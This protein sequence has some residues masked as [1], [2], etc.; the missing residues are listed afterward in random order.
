MHNI[1]GVSGSVHVSEWVTSKGK[2]KFHRDVLLAKN[3][4]PAGWYLHLF[5]TKKVSKIQI[6]DFEASKVRKT[7]SKEWKLFPNEDS[8]L[9]A[10]GSSN[11]Y[12]FNFIGTS[13]DGEAGLGLTIL[14][15]YT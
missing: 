10:D 6:W 9:E 12:N 4:P 5:F 14:I 13:K 2:F 11:P 3:S 15:C 1:H 8:V 7:K